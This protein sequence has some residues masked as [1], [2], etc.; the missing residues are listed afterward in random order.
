[1]PAATAF[2]GQVAEAPPEPISASVRTGRIICWFA[3]EKS[4]RNRTLAAPGQAHP[5]ASL[6][7]VKKKDLIKDLQY[8]VAFTFASK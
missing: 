3:E 5:F 8:I 4:I 2:C 1:M 6:L 7:F